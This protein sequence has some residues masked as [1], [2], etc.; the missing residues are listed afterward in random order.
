[1]ILVL[2][3]VEFLLDPLASLSDAQFEWAP[4]AAL[5]TINH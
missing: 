4:S 2:D 5:Q 1:M 3:E